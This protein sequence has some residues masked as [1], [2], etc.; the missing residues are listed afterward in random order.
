MPVWPP[1]ALLKPL[2]LAL[3]VPLS[4]P[5]AEALAE[6]PLPLAAPLGLPYDGEGGVVSEVIIEGD[7]EAEVVAVCVEGVV[8]V[9]APLEAV[10]QTLAVPALPL[11]L[12]VC[13]G[14]CEVVWQALKLTVELLL[15]AKDALC[16]GDCNGEELCSNA[17]AEPNSEGEGAKENVWLPV[18]LT[19][20]EP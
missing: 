14:V 13:I 6:M 17:L 4:A 12:I 5:V 15:P 8:A 1:E 16:E 2:A 20:T 3:P 10:P 9:A 7:D 18:T 11:A 19:H